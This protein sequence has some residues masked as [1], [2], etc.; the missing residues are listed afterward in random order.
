M[1]AAPLLVALGIALGGCATESAG[2]P[3]EARRQS[4][5]ELLGPTESAGYARALEPREFVFP[6]D[7]GP[8]PEF[9]TEWWYFT[10]NLGSADGRRFGYQATFFR[11]AL[12][13]GEVPEA[14]ARTSAWATRQAWMAHF[15]VTAAG[16]GGGGRFRSFERFSR[17]A[18]DLAGARAAPFRVW[19]EDWEAEAVDGSGG[20]PPLRLRLAD[21]GAAID[22]VLGPGKPPVFH[23][24]RGLSRKGAETG[25]ASYYYSFT[26]LPTRGR[27]EV[28][29]RSFRVEGASWMDREWSTSVLEEGQV[30]W[31]WLSLQL[32][33]GR[34]LMVF[35]LRRADGR[36]DPYAGGTLVGPDG[37]S[38]HLGPG[39]FRL[40]PVATWA[41]PETGAV[42][43]ARWRLEIPGERLD[44]S[45]EPIVADQ[46][47]RGSFVY[48]EGAV[49]IEGT[50]A[51]EPIAGRGYIELTGY[52][53]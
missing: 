21:A 37:A 31:D 19:L 20:V 10:G 11:S 1:R 33:D 53:S 43:P 39:A 16:D 48:W 52:D 7:H 47:L 49:R 40:D 42:Y 9:R 45:I 26:R 13:P 8:H 6:D 30:G 5:V 4:V 41:S 22:L 29:G 15:A 27:V 17:G 38:R 28:D 44:L 3:P 50:G 2:P 14:P 34:D 18:L 12:A 23:G 51:G 35:R 24:E 36:P 46:E 32:D 25:N